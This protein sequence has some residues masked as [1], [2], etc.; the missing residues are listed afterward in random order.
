MDS[1]MTAR[2]GYIHIESLGRSKTPRL[3][4]VRQGYPPPYQGIAK[5]IKRRVVSAIR[6]SEK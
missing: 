3:G 6:I 4:Q 2:A 5:Q 1:A